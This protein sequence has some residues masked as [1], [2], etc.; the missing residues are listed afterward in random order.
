MNIFCI[1][2]AGGTARVIYNSW[3]NHLPPSLRIV[4]L[5]LAGHGHRIAEPFH[6][7]MEAAVAGLVAEIR[8]T[9]YNTR[10]AIYGHSLGTLITYELTKALDAAGLPPPVALFLSGRR[11]PHNCP[12][13]RNFHLLSDPL[14]LREI[15]NLGGTPKGFFQDPELVRSFLPIIRNDYRL[16]E[17]YRFNGT[18]HQTSADIVFFSSDDDAVVAG[19]EKREWQSYTR[20]KFELVEFSGGHFFIHPQREAICAWIARKLASAQ[21]SIGAFNLLV[22]NGSS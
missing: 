7:N 3:Q 10:Y 12:K 11:P 5:E 9:A 4:P 17:T 6:E 18:I 20:G 16:L 8:R 14:L 22:K 15:E 2:Y 19:P 13:P 21:R 1:P